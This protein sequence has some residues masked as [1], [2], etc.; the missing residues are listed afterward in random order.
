MKKI[1]ITGANSYI[2]TSFETYLKENHP[3]DSTMSV[4]E[5][6]DKARAY[7]EGDRF[8]LE[9]GVTIDELSPAGAV[10]S[11]E[12][13]ARHRNAEGGVM[14]GAIFTLIDLAFAAAANWGLYKAN[15]TKIVAKCFKENAASYKMLSSCMRK[16][17]EDE[18]FFYF[19]KLV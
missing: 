13:T 2:G 4:F 8:A 5:T 16:K 11:F 12:I 14:G 6:I 7:F 15:L 19:E 3:E 17:G 10:C 9:N 1:L 18:K